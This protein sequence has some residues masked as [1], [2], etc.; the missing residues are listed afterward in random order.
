MVLR[1]DDEW[2][3]DSWY[4]HDG[5]LHHAFY[6]HASR[7]LGDPELRHR[8][9]HIGHATSPDLRT[10]T[11]HADALSV[12]SESAFDDW[13]T[14][15]GSVVRDA[16]GMW[17]MFYTGSSHGDGGDIQRIGAATSTDLYS[18]TRASDVP[19]IEADFRWYE[20]LD[21]TIWHD[22]AWRDPFVFQNGFGIWHMLVTAR[23]KQ[24]PTRSRG[25]VGHCVS[26][27]L[28]HWTVLE[29]LTQPNGGFGQMEVLQVEV[30][31]GTP[32]LVFSCGGGELD[33]HA[34]SRYG[35]GGVFSVTG[36]STIGPFDIS[37]ASRFPT[38]SVYA[39][40]LVRHHGTWGLIG[41]RNIEQGQFVGELTD[42][43]PVT[44]IPG[45]GLVPT[46]AFG[47]SL[48]SGDQINDSP[49]GPH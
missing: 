34:L 41:F 36:P 46:D 42:P 45:V 25:V 6:L 5:A 27:D 40:R 4:A 37:Q 49:E 3:W 19:V 43:T 38:D 14:W 24:G 26:R 31:D 13:T 39:A 22:Q 8:Y 11:V 1:L 17:W 44:S 30:V 47:R 20:P 35:S 15:T 7:S 48:A 18:W 29:P 10:W 32:T 12:S 21:K 28:R 23:A 9:P 33:E 2:I 16:G